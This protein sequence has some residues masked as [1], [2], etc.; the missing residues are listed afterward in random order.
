MYIYIYIYI[1]IYKEEAKESDKR[2]KLAFPERR[3]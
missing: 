3:E 1:Y 2:G